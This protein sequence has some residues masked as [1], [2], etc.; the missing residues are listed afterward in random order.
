MKTVYEVSDNGQ[1]GT[2]AKVV[3]F[4]DD[5]SL[6][7]SV[8]LGRGPM[9]NG[10]GKIREIPVWESESD[11]PLDVREKISNEKERVWKQTATAALKMAGELRV[12]LVDLH[13]AQRESILKSILGPDDSDDDIPF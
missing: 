2:D 4:C 12:L 5:F 10:N 13:P 3:G 9:G 8:A 7:E 1:D 6:A 11:L